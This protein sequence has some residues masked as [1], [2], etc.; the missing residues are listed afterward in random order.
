MDEEN[1]VIDKQE[2]EAPQ[3][4]IE[5]SPAQTE[6]EPSEESN[7]AELGDK[8][9]MELDDESLKNALKSGTDDI[10]KQAKD[11]AIKETP[12]PPKAEDPNQ[13]QEANQKYIIDRMGNE[14]GQYRQII[15]SWEKNPQAAIDYF[16]AKMPAVEPPKELSPEEQF[17]AL[18]ENPAKF[19]MDQLEAKQTE[20]MR[21]EQARSAERNKKAVQ[22]NKIAPDLSDNAIEITRIMSQ[23]D[24]LEQQQ[25]VDMCSAMWEFP[26]DIW[27]H[28][29]QRA[30][31]NKALA[32]KDKEIE[33][34]KKKPKNLLNNINNA[35]K[36]V[37]TAKVVGNTIEDGSQPEL[38]ESEIMRLSDAEL[39]EY[40]KRRKD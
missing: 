17:A 38:T 30:R 5:T 23:E 27:Y 29:N 37:N 32:A 3:E 40:L 6:S 11:K 12:K 21:M 34:L 39:K 2:N 18:T 15:G 24:G 13:K 28:Y 16:K 35:A 9:I 4:V 25:V 14:L 33:T 10:L 1:Q 26:I 7:T 8:E 19:V 36:Q 31:V 22:L 20:A